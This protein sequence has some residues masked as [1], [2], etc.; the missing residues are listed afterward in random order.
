V[1]AG[2]GHRRRWSLRD[3]LTFHDATYVALAQT[4]GLP[5]VTADARLAHAP[6]LPCAVELIS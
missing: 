5:P 3:D 6:R 2:T 1:S 4:P